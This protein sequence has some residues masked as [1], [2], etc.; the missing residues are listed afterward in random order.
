[1][2]SELTE[3]EY[4]PEPPRITLIGVEGIGKSTF[5][6]LADNPIFIPTE[7]GLSGLPNVRKFPQSKTFKQ[8]MGYIEEL[9]TKNHDRKTVVVDSVDW[10]ERLIHDQ[11]CKEYNVDN[12]EKVL[13]GFGKGYSISLNLWREYLD[14][15]EYL[16]LNRGMTIIQVAHAQIRKF[17]DPLM[18]AYD[19]YSIKLQEGKNVSAAGLILEYSDIVLFANYYTGIKKEEKVFTKQRKI[20]VGNGDRF[21]YTEERP[22]FKAKN[23]YGLPAEIPF[24]I[25]GQY[26]SAIAS[27][28][29]YFNTTE[30]GVKN[31][32]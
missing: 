12:I 5:G 21:L 18:E 28:I 7:N 15:L 4:R 11:V 8:V 14:G 17:E 6:S 19:R 9:G 2:T 23:R 26:W 3:E 32:Q 16:R 22:G 10:L 31:G 20:A 1:M 25:E 29:P 30:V 27:K 24:D 13:Q